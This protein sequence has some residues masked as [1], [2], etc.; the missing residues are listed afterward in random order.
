MVA[1]AAMPFMTAADS[2]RGVAAVYT[3]S[4]L[5]FVPMLFAGVA[6]LALRN[7]DAQARVLV[8]R[9]AIAAL[10][11]VFVGR[12]LPLH[13]MAWVMPSALAAPLVELGRV[14]ITSASRIDATTTRFGLIDALFA[15]YACGVVVVLSRTL[16]ATIRTHRLA[17]N[18]GVL[19]NEWLALL[20]GAR[21]DLGIRR[22]VRLVVSD[23]ARV[24]MTWGLIRPT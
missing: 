23:G 17:T 14:Q 3:V 8:W 11:L 4:L 22:R 19:D 12:M 15:I 24:P 10:L 7:G 18:A 6:L 9:S 20:N 2:A 21:T 5:A 1:A 13:W 16:I